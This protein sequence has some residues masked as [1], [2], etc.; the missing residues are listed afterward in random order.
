[1]GHA[2]EPRHFVEI[3]HAVPAREMIQRPELATAH[4]GS[5]VGQIGGHP[6]VKPRHRLGE[7]Q[8]VEIADHIRAGRAPGIA[9]Q[10]TAQ[11]Q[12]PPVIEVIF[13][14]LQRRTG[15]EGRGAEIARGHAHGHRRRL[16]AAA[17]SRLR[18]RA[19]PAG[20]GPAHAWAVSGVGMSQP[21]RTPALPSRAASSTISATSGRLCAVSTM[22]RVKGRSCHHAEAGRPHDAADRSPGRAAGHGWPRGRRPG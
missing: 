5:L 14:Q 2:R 11:G 16:A 3:L 8:L 7:A 19:A 18:P 13:L 21:K 9:G 17:G 12:V 10:L 20:R 15:E 4:L 6:L 1:M 22:F